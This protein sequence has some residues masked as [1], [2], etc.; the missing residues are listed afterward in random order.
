ME[1]LLRIE[2]LR[3]EADELY[4]RVRWLEADQEGNPFPIRVLSCESIASEMVYFT[5]EPF[6][7][8][9]YR[10]DDG[11][12]HIGQSPPRAIKTESRIR[13]PHPSASEP[14]DGAIFLAAVLED[15]WDLFGYMPFVYIVNSWTGELGY[16]VRVEFVPGF[17]EQLEIEVDANLVNGDATLAIRQI[18]YIIKSHAMGQIAPHPIPTNIKDEPRAIAE[19][20]FQAYGQR[21][22]FATYEDTLGLK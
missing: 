11:Q 4:G 12:H 18:D 1:S 9:R 16:K 21:G 17:T 2:N 20:S 15:K 6:R 14:S 19:Y 7:V 5:D 22:L 10:G 3:V 13:H 8:G